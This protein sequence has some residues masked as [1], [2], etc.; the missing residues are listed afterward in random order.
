MIRADK[1]SLSRID[2]QTT[3]NRCDVTPLFADGEA[4]AALVD[5]LLDQMN[6]VAFD[7][8]AA[9]D[10]LGFILGTAIAVRAGKG[11]IAIRKGGK[12][13]V[14][15]ERREFLDYTKQIKSLELRSDMVRPGE[16]V[17]IVDEWIET[18]AQVQAAIALAEHCGAIVAGVVT[19][20]IDAD[21]AEKLTANG[22]RV[23]A[24]S[25]GRRLTDSRRN[26]D[27]PLI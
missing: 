2:R 14:V 26:G 5:H 27:R 15:C 18:G 12:L 21:A 11:V 6:G 9:I 17:L 16:R 24:A 4:F 23:F 7:R 19:I 13:P 10:A 1:D 22:Y 8:V 3:G 20:N 25:G